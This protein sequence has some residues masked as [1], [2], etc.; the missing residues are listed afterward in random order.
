MATIYGNL[1]GLKSS[2]IKQLQRLYEQRQPSDR[3]ITSAYAQQLAALSHDLHQPVCSYVNRRGQVVRVGVGTPAQTQL[4]PSELPRHGGER[5]SGIRCLAAQPQDPDPASLVALVNQRL[6]ALVVLNV[7]GKG[8]PRSNHPPELIKAAYVAHLVPDFDRPW[9]VA[10]LSL[11]ELT[12]EDFGGLVREWEA[13]LQDAG[14]DLT[15]LQPTA[16]EQDRVLLVGLLSDGTTEQQF[17]EGLVELERLVDSAG[18]EVVGIIQQKRSQPHPQTVVGQGK[19]QEVALQAQTL[20][21]NLIVFDRDIS[22]AQARNLEA[23]IG[24]RVVDRTEVILDIFAQRA[25]SQAGKLQVELAQL[26]YQLPRLRGRGQAM[27]RLGA[28]I[29]TRGP[30]ETKLETERRTIQRRIAQLQ[31]EVNQLQAHRARLRQQRERQAVPVVALVGYTNAGKSTLLN[32]LTQADVYTADQL[33][34]TLDPTTRRLS[35]PGPDGQV[36][37]VL[38]TD[39]VGFIHHLPPALMD[40]FRATLEEVTEADALLHL[41]D[42]SHPAWA[43]HIRSVADILAGLPGMPGT[44]LLVFN[45]IDCVA[46]DVLAQA[47]QAYP[48][49][50]FISASERLGLE[51]LKQRILQLTY[52]PL[53]QYT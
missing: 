5:L 2:Q 37:E 40:A 50:L 13:E 30:G 34:A 46:S 45:K 43:D 28:G 25:Q 6:D 41:V 33:F 32:V 31:Q 12:A 1:Q 9:S 3:L 4:P 17:E 19:V 26:A 14:F 29:G 21:A 7:N 20:G 44:T 53:H 11:D 22:A 48:D 27:S 52:R 35:V 10:P 39:T 51:T 38:L 23:Q 8:S 42:L 24:V 47:Q 36:R 16:S 18:G 49:A 15:Q